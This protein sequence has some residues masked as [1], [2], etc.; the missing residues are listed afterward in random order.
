MVIV[1]ASDTHGLHRELDVPPG[2]L[3][4]HTGD[5]TMMS[6]SI[7][8]IEDFNEWLGELPHRWKYFYRE[9]RR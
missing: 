3:F 8:E 5:F 9:L 4:I 6:R 7:S 1:I 2:D